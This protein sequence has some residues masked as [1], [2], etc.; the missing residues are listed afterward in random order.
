MNKNI[1]ALKA[2]EKIA[3]IEMKEQYKSTKEGVVYCVVADNCE[4]ELKIVEAS[5]KR[6]ILL[7]ANYKHELKNS[8]RLNNECVKN[9]KKLEALEIIKRCPKEVIEEVETYYSFEEL[10]EDWGKMAFIKSKEE[11]ELVR[12]VL[13]L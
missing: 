12:E 5:L 1:S 4:K 10:Y 9:L 7:E 11:F 13:D 3:N 6:A 8:S 2:L